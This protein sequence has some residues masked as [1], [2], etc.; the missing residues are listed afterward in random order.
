M[1]RIPDTPVTLIARMAAQVTGE[2]EATWVKFFELYQPVIRHFAEFA[3]ARSDTDDVV[4]DVMVKLVDVFRSG[5]YRP[6]KGRFRA[7]LATITRR[8]VINRW[9]KAQARAADRHVS[10]NRTTAQEIVVQPEA[11]AIL[12][13]KW[14]LA[15]HAA[16]VEHVLTRTALAQRSKDVYRAYVLEERPIGEVAQAFGVSRNVVSQIK[17]RVDAMIADFEA[18][19]RD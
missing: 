14:R 10:L 1:S 6:E 8:E 18:M 15:Q 3:G 4:Q 11:A 13:A 17:T 7:F 2:D 12:D 16:A 9:Q 5:A 19:L